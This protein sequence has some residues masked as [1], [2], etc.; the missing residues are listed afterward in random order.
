MS[1]IEFD[2]SP[3]FYPELLTLHTRGMCGKNC[4]TLSYYLPWVGLTLLLFYLWGRWQIAR[5]EA[6]QVMGTH[7]SS[8]HTLH[9]TAS[10][11]Y[12][13]PETER[14]VGGKQGEKNKL[15]NFQQRFGFPAVRGIF[16][17]LGFSTTRWVCRVSLIY[18]CVLV[19]VSKKSVVESV[20]KIVAISILLL[21][22]EKLF[23]FI[24]FILCDTLFDSSAYR[25]I[26]S[27]I[28]AI[29]LDL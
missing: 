22:R 26:T 14:E 6:C 27:Q 12:Q 18:D 15:Q 3:K 21:L 9:V 8:V 29:D 13:W 2:S 24:S 28:W 17:L 4:N 11:K 7:L 10:M 20:R 25:S 19:S 5:G 23:N 16:S 1:L